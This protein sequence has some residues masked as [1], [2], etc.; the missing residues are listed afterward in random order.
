MWKPEGNINGSLKELSICLPW[1]D[2]IS[3]ALSSVQQR[4][5]WNPKTEWDIIIRLITSVFD[6]SALQVNRGYIAAQ[7]GLF[8]FRNI[9]LEITSDIQD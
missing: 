8:M 9:K 1:E 5:F 2:L 6:Y 4:I 7:E 3:Q